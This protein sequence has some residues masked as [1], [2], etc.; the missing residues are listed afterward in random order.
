MCICT[1]ALRLQF[2]SEHPE[3]FMYTGF[4]QVLVPL[5]LKGC[6]LKPLLHY[7]CLLFSLVMFTCILYVI[8]DVYFSHAFVM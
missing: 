8:C 5:Y 7:V 2:V 6:V 3:V 4:V 1:S